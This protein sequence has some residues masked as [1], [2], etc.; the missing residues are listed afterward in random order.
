MSNAISKRIRVPNGKKGREAI[1]RK[2]KKQNVVLLSSSNLHKNTI[3]FSI[4]FINHFS[5]SISISIISLSSTLFIISKL[6]KSTCPTDIPIKFSS[7]IPSWCNQRSGGIHP[8]KTHIHHID[9]G[10]IESP[11]IARI[12]DMTL[13][14]TIPTRNNIHQQAPPQKKKWEK[15]AKIEKQQIQNIKKVWKI[16]QKNFQNRKE[17]W[18]E[19]AQKIAKGGQGKRGGKTKNCWESASSAAMFC[20]EY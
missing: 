12:A 15:K 18:R 17:T 13:P 8:R 3:V 14:E 11:S 6:F 4:I 2:Q 20:S 1:D 19:K 7:S 5:I 16:S 9:N 10:G